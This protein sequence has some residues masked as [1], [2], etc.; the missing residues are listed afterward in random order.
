LSGTNADIYWEVVKIAVWITVAV[1]IELYYAH[2]ILYMGVKWGLSAYRS[3]IA[4]DIRA[5]KVK[6][7]IQAVGERIDDL[8][9]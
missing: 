9:P 2:D 6:A 3:P 1:I 8:K 5:G 7:T 4:T